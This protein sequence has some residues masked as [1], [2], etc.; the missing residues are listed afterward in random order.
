M[1]KRT[2]S[3][4][5][6]ELVS[7]FS[8]A[9]KKVFITGHT[10]FK[11]AWLSQWLLNKGAQVKGFSLKPDGDESLFTALD[12][13]NTMESQIGDIRDF[14][15]LNQALMD[16]DP[17]IIFHMAAQ[18]LV[19]ESYREPVDNFA[20]NVTGT[21]HVLESARQ[22]KKLKSM[23]IV[24]TDKCYENKEL[25]RAFKESDPLGGH[26]PYSASKAC[27]EIVTSS[28]FRSFFQESSVGLAT[29]RAG[30]V[31]GGGD[32]AKDRLL[33]DVFRA[34]AHDGRLEIR[35]PEAVRP[36]Q[37]VLDP[38]NG[39]IKVAEHLWNDPKKFSE[40]WNFGPTQE[41]TVSVRKVVEKLLEKWP[42]KFEILMNGD[43]TQPHEAQLLYLDCEKATTKL[44]WSPQLAIDEALE[45]TSEWYRSFFANE[46]VLKLT[47]QQI[48]KFERKDC[49]HV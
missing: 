13:E 45:W 20:T 12:L 37:H 39:Y 2:G 40:G 48:E 23:V 18:T 36:W 34:I 1:G 46:D 24:T 17:E 26:D 27:A 19:R 4:E 7:L 49:S 10:G 43:K 8:W 6:L 22:L 38:L 28:Y 21:V 29:V 3:L 32:W 47:K 9:G 42:G 14:T 41:G 35:N 30:N 44:N 15:T 25:G 5:G 16:F 11:G 33:P 31:I